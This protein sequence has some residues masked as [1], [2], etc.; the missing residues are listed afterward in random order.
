MNVWMCARV[1]ACER[2]YVCFRTQMFKCIHSI[3]Q[4]PVF[5]RALA[6]M[7]ADMHVCTCMHAYVFGRACPHFV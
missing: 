6:S 1:R 4:V 3:F 5:V 7:C 2:A